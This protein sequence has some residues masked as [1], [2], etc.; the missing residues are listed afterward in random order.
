MITSILK[1]P[2]TFEQSRAALDPASTS[3]ATKLA[4]F[5]QP[6]E[7]TETEVVELLS[8]VVPGTGRAVLLLGTTGSG[9]STFIQSLT[10]RKHLGLARLE[11]IDCS[12]LSERNKLYEL[13]ARLQVAADKARRDKGITAVSIDYLESLGGIKDEEKRAFFQTLNGLLR[14]SPMLV[15][16][17]VTKHE[18][19]SSMIAEAKS[20]SGTVFDVRVPI[21][22]FKGPKIEMFPSIVRNTISVFNESRMLQD[23]LL[24]DAELD[25]VRD[26]LVADTETDPTI[27]NYI[28]NV[29]IHWSQKTGRLKTVNAK[30]PKP[31]EVWCVFCHPTA[32]DVVSIFATKG[33][34]AQSAWIA[35]HS[36]LWEYVP[37]TQRAARWKNPTR[38]Q[39]AIGGAL[40]TRILHL[41]PQSL[42]SICMAYSSD[43]KLDPVRAA[44]PV[45]WKDKSKA[46]DYLSTSALFKQLTGQAPSKGKTKGG[47]AAAARQSATVPFE[48]LNKIVAGSGNDRYVNHAI[49]ECLKE[50]L[51]SDFGVFSEQVHPWI[52]SITPDIRIDTPDGRQI[53]LEFCYTNNQKPGG[54]ADYVLDKLA[55]YMDQ[56]EQYVGGE[57]Y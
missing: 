17:P 24:T 14:K 7:D 48:V 15:V 11:S 10:W 3:Y 25:K 30:L 33:S 51:S 26:D 29:Q 32:E 34:Q 44:G 39:Y 41:S 50:K 37:G 20:V 49:A 52:P 8:R 23:F 16:W 1:L 21:L 13:G 38:L 40:V 18:D 19:A 53:C 4:Q 28:Q 35:Y 56:L 46:K 57:V 45:E 5:V 43:A 42:V 2:E 6:V 36:K 9:K 54:V 55:V 31:N 47:P 22:K 27:R 12:D